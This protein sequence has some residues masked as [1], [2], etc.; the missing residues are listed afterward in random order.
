MN[1]DMRKMIDKV[2]SFKQFV[3]ENKLNIDTKVSKN[4][5]PLVMYHGGSFSGVEFKG[6]G[7]T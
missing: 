5:K 1:E 4:G 2:K 6:T 3:N 7:Q